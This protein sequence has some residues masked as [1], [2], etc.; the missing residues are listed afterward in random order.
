MT[1]DL[2]SVGEK[3]GHSVKSLAI[4][5]YRILAYCTDF[6]KRKKMS[7]LQPWL[8]HIIYI[9]FHPYV[10]QDGGEMLEGQP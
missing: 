5:L 1:E 7:R 8:R 10:C 9:F 2:A 4:N 3:S 6:R